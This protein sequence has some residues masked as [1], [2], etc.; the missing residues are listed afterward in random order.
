M[1]R[2]GVPCFGPG[3][4]A[5][6]TIATPGDSAGFRRFSAILWVSDHP[7]LEGFQAF[8]SSSWG[9][10][11]RFTQDCWIA[12]RLQPAYNPCSLAVFRVIRRKKGVDLR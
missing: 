9:F 6:N 2:G 4:N 7:I 11:P 5:L 12:S 8:L 3:G 10:L 1:S